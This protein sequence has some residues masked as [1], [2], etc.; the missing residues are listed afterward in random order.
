M[1]NITCIKC[2]VLIMNVLANLS[3]V[4]ADL[5]IIL[6]E[7]IQFWSLN[8]RLSFFLLNHVVSHFQSCGRVTSLI[9]IVFWQMGRKSAVALFLIVSS[10]VYL[11]FFEPC[12][13]RNFKIVPFLSFLFVSQKEILRKKILVGTVA[14]RN[15]LLCSMP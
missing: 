9:N 2:I 5:T 10:Y 3:L 15:L 6:Q 13:K 12:P 7:A 14:L 11:R 8:C 4:L 1:R